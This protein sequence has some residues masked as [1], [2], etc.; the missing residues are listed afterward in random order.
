M[1]LKIITPPTT[2]IVTVD[3][4]V[5]FMRV[6]SP[7]AAEEA[8][9][10]TMIT[11]ARKWCEEYLRRAIGVQTLELI[12]DEFPSLGNQAILLRPPVVSVTSV[13]YID[14]DGDEQTMVEDVDYY[15]AKDSE[16][17]EIRPV[18]YWPYSLNT[19]DAVRV[20]YQAGYCADESPI[21]SEILP[22]TIRT[23][24]LMQVA[25]LYNNR[26]A[27]VEKPLSVNQTLERLLSMYR[28]EMSL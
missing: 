4:A 5:Q 12:L 11:A 3:E 8:L 10:E 1:S 6:D 17:G 15:L 13:K 16:P 7:S 22:E 19:A 25:D 18:A 9:I 20:R 28:L 21:L 23:A 26:E 24:I 14:A 27:Q 2:E